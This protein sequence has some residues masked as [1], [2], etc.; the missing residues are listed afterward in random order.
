MIE[1]KLNETNTTPL[2]IHANGKSSREFNGVFDNLQSMFMKNQVPIS[3]DID[4]DVTVITWKGGKYANQET[5][6]E[7]CMR[8]YDFPLLVLEWPENT[9]FWE[10]SKS[11]VTK[12]LEAI[13]NGYV[14]TK[15]VMWFDAGDVILLEHPSV[16]LEKYMELFSGKL[17][18][19]AER[20]NYPKDNRMAP[21]GEV[22]RN[23]FDSVVKFD[24]TKDNTTFK[25]LNSGCL[26]GETKQ[27]ETFLE[28]TS[29][30]G[31]DEP[32]NDTVMCRIAQYDNSEE[33]VVDNNCEL[34]VCLYGVEMDDVELR[35]SVHE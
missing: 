7:T 16:I 8:F 11:K 24:N 15:Y 25:Y 30:I 28:H 3:T 23:R 14:K 6:L 1:L 5:I 29:T 34:F 12:T 20:N 22:I 35:V 21:V 31:I 27:L 13:K 26:V 2:V 19:N 9:N 4:F 17:V 32:I 10:G 33:I 18:F